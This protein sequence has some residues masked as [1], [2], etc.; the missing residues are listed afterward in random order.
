MDDAVVK[1]LEQLLERNRALYAL[2]EAQDWDAFSEGIEE[3]MARLNRLSRVDFNAL[4]GADREMMIQCLETLLVH[5]AQLRQCIQA[6]L[7][8]LSGE[9]SSLRKSRSSAHA[10]TAV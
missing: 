6:R 7:N 9:M 10:Y 2:V 8:T 4:P 3:Y 5:D 1:D